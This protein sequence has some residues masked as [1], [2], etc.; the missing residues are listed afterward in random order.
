MYVWMEVTRDKYELP[1]VIADTAR[2]LSR[3]CGATISTIKSSASRA[4][5]GNH[6]GRVCPYRSILIEDEKG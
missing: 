1:I 4:H 5:T 2:D 3:K 6:K